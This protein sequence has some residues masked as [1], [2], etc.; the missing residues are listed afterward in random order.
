MDVIPEKQPPKENSRP[1]K[2]KEKTLGSGSKFMP[3]V[4]RKRLLRS[5]RKEKDPVARERLR[6]CLYRKEGWSIRKTTRG[7]GLAYSTV[8][9]RLVRMHAGGLNRRFERRRAGRKRI[10]TGAVLKEIKKWL[11]DSPQR[12]KFEAG[13]WQI[14]MVREM[15]RERFGTSCRVRTLKRM[16]RRLGLS[17]SKSRCPTPTRDPHT[18]SANNLTD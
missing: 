3:N 13:S 1:E 14:N 11:N 7:M 16:L 4:S 15:L 8:R 2:S 17:Y 5:I 10:L 18:C 6:A 12:Y 9:D